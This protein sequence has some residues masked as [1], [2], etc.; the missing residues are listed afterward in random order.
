[1]KITLG[2][3]K[4]SEQALVKLSTSTLPINLA[5]KVSKILKIVSAEL[6]ELE[7]HRKKLVEK[8]GQ[9]NGE[10]SLLV[11][12]DNI[13]NFIN[14]INPLLEEEI[15]LPFEKIK[16]NALPNDLSFTPL[17]ISQLED[18]IDFED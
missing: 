13:E 2:R 11:S 17:E 9:D 8:Y 3:L 4:S 15:D 18:F 10:G 1:M 12:A 7:E 16:S 5:Y 14:E 6:T